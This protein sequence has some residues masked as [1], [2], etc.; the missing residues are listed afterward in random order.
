MKNFIQKGEVIDLIAPADVV[1]GEGFL[2]GELFGVATKDATNGTSVPC[3]V[4]GVVELPKLSALAL[5]Q[6]DRVF[7]D[8]T[9]GEVNDTATSQVCIGHAIEDAANPSSTVKV[10]L[11]GSTPAGT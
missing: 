6:G 11:G 2:V 4:T 10:R 9:P 8:P 5:S 1:S 3:V 7:W